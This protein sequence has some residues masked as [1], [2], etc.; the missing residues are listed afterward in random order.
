MSVSQLLYLS[1]DRHPPELVALIRGHLERAEFELVQMSYDDGVDALRDQLQC[2]DLLFCAPGRSLEPAVYD[3]VDN[4]KLVQLWSSGFDKFDINTPRNLGIPVANN[5]GANRI[6]VAEHTIMLML[7]V[8]KRLPENHARTVEGRWSG[9]S[10]G[11]DMFLLRGKTLGLIGL[12]AIGRE[13]ALRARAFGMDIVYSERVRLSPQE[14]QDLGVRF[15]PLE[16]L[17]AVSDIV[18][19]HLHLTAETERMLGEPELD[20][21]KRGSV[22]INVSRAQLIDNDHLLKALRN[23]HIGGAGFDVYETEPTVDGDPLLT[24]PNVVC[25]PHAA[26]T[27]DSHNMA[28][29][30]CID[31]LLRVH[32]GSKPTWVVNGVM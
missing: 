25:T 15:V 20:S 12:G 14:E 7:A 24:H 4:L 17:L 3:G 22:I 5:G 16:E 19:P 13:V 21:M 29:E 30:A 27:R 1:I 11:M 26:N 28:M 23:G 10:H 8:Y 32:G 2:S 31:N 9:N 18:S 6:A